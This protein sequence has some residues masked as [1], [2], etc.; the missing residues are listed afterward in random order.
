MARQWSDAAGFSYPNEDDEDGAPGTPPVGRSPP[1]QEN[2][3]FLLRERDE[4]DRPPKWDGMHPETNTVGYVKKLKQPA[5]TLTLQLVVLQTA[6]RET[7][8][9]PF[10]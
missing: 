10:Q 2:Y 5:P 8:A 6:L 3:K 9:H 7:F 4:K 1:P